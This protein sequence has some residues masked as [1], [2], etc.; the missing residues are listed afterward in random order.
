MTQKLLFSTF[1]SLVFATGPGM[2]QEQPLDDFIACEAL[3]NNLE[4]LEC[5]EEVLQEK[6]QKI[7]AR[8]SPEPSQTA[9]SPVRGDIVDANAEAANPA[10]VVQDHSSAKV[11][12]GRQSLQ[13]KAFTAQIVRIWRPHPRGRIYFELDNGS[14][15]RQTSGKWISISDDEKGPVEVFYG[16]FGGW[17]MKIKNKTG[18]SF[19][20]PVN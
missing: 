3:S 16:L 6:K 13:D 2:A 20:A 18:L 4:R 9:P 14:V 5:F 17:R 12:T 7:E 19:I 10:E 1:T 15:W 11:I 8:A